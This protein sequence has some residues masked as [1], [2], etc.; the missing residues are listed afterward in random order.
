MKR[1]SIKF[2]ASYTFF[3]YSPILLD[4]EKFKSSLRVSGS[5][6]TSGELEEG[7][8][9][10]VE[11]KLVV[12]ALSIDSSNLEPGSVSSWYEPNQEEVQIPFTR[13]GE[14]LIVKPNWEVKSGSLDIIGEVSIELRADVDVAEFI[15]SIS[16]LL[17]GVDTPSGENDPLGTI[18]FLNPPA[19]P[20]ESS[21]T[22][23]GKP[24]DSF[25]YVDYFIEQNGSI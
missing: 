24:T 10:S 1:I 9:W 7:S 20:R 5:V 13:G 22:I 6:E 3:A 14:E 4:T 16:L 12:G 17:D 21:A 15:E 11:E 23:D 8:D 25:I 19:S 2:Q 18:Y